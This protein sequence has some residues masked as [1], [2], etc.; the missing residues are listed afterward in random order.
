MELQVFSGTDI[1]ESIGINVQF[2]NKSQKIGTLSPGDEEFTLSNTSETAD[3]SV[4]GY[5]VP[6]LYPF[7]PPNIFIFI[8]IFLTQRANVIRA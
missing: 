4:S 3:V 1:K 5:T 8:L 7:E 6:Y 2:H